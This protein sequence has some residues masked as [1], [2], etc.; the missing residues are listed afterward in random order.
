[1][2]KRSAAHPF[3]LVELAPSGCWLW[4]GCRNK[5]GY[6]VIGD[7]PAHRVVY[8]M[9]IGLIPFRHLVHH[10]CQVPRCVNPDRLEAVTALQHAA[11]HAEL[12]K[13]AA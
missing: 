2:A 6:G 5:G 3:D 8:E 12:R 11:R 13:N 1:M 9:V 4:T 10:K 7:Q